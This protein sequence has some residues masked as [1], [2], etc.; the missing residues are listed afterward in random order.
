MS[1]AVEIIVDGGQ[2]DGRVT[3]HFLAEDLVAVEARVTGGRE[4]VYE[5][6]AYHT[7]SGS[8]EEEVA[9]ALIE[10]RRSGRR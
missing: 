10:K 4:H 2:M 3:R 5:V 6:H 8:G 9:R 7:T 1:W